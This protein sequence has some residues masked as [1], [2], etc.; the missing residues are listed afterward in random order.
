MIGR[1]SELLNCPYCKERM[2]CT[3]MT[4]LWRGENEVTI[5]SYECEE[6]GRTYDDGP[7]GIKQVNGGNNGP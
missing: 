6:C 4:K 1:C 3:A 5:L 2:P 7:D